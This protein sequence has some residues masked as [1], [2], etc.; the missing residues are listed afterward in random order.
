M[1]DRIISAAVLLAASMILFSDIRLLW[2]HGE[3]E[4]VVEGKYVVS[5]MLVP[6]GEG[7]SLQFFF[8][9]FKTGQRL[10]VPISFHIKIRD[11]QAQKF[12]FASPT[13]R[14]SNGVGA[15]VYQFSRDGFYEVFLEFDTA[16]KLGTIY[17]PED[18]YL[19]KYQSSGR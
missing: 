6:Q 2:A 13:I 12:V 3:P 7:M 8:R 5:L 19:H 15:V 16:D 9:D 1:R 10:L 4:K 14:A 11:Y 18:W 17:R